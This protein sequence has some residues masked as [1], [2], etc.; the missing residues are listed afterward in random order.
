VI[1]L[2]GVAGN[3]RV[4]EHVA[5]FGMLPL[6]LLA[7]LGFNWGKQF[8]FPLVFVLFAIPIGGELVPALQK[9][10]A[11]IAIKLLSLTSIPLLTEGL[12]ISIPQ[13]RFVVAEACSGI[14]FFV[15]CV[16]YGFL[17]AYLT[18]RRPRLWVIFLCTAVLL[19]VIA[20]GLRVFLTIVIGYI[21][22][23]DAATGT[24]HL[25]FGWGFFAFIL[26]LLTAFGEWLRRYQP[27]FDEA[28]V[29]GVPHS[30]WGENNNKIIFTLL[31]VILLAVSVATAQAKK[32]ADGVTENL[33]L[34]L[35]NGEFAVSRVLDWQPTF[36]GA[37]NVW[38]GQV[39]D[40]NA[41]VVVAWYQRDEVGHELIHSGNLL[42][43]KN[44]WSEDE[45]K[46][47]NVE[48]VGKVRM[49]RLVSGS[50]RT[51][52]IIYWYELPES[53][54]SNAVATKLNQ[55]LDRVFGGTGAAAMVAVSQVSGA[56]NKFSDDEI[57]ALILQLRPT[58]RAAIPF[59]K[60]S[61]E[62]AQ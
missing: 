11:F 58:I 5:A 59:T 18:F 34:S 50:G 22:G 13:G 19:P 39:A 23:M 62:A 43:R 54:E 21:W 2:I 9:I 49:T 57:A 26:I 31:S 25:V 35:L 46:T 40:N 24:D 12:Y 37:T 29:A 51:R 28:G 8:W 55:A 44:H 17:Y 15:A 48:A 52:I 42:Y 16:A 33:D 30:S 45:S 56:T 61:N 47:V 27:E 60:V 20:N 6:L 7:M 1:G 4:L 41:D 14:R 36:V 38:R 10:T 32:T 3:I 53:V